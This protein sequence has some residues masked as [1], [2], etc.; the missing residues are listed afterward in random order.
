MAQKRKSWREKLEAQRP[1]HGTIVKILVP[2]PL[3]VVALMEQIPKG[4][5]VTDER[6]RDRLARD[7]DADRTCGRMTGI[8]IRIAAEVAEEDAAEGKEQITPYWRVIAKDGSL[9]PNLPGGAQHQKELLAQEG[10]TVARQ[11]K[12]L[13]VV[14]F[15]QSLLEL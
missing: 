8:F 13:I 14:N 3:D 10:H 15:E 11:G 4:K 5:L 7:N 9:K 1:I 12:R 2:K 6:I